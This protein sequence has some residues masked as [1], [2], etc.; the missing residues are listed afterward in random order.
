M[1]R[2][3]ALPSR[4]S[5]TLPMG[6]YTD[7]EILRA[8][9]YV[10]KVLDFSMSYANPMNFLRRISKADNYDIQTRHS[11]QVLYGDLVARLPAHGAP[12]L[13]RRCR[14]R[15]A[16]PRGP[17]ARRVDAD[18]GALLDLHEQELLA[19]P[20]SC[21]ILPASHHAS[22]LPQEVTRTRSSCA[23]AVRDR[24]G[25]QDVPEGVVG[26]DEEQDRTCSAST[27]TSARDRATGAVTRVVVACQHARDE[28]PRPGAL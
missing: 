23:P 7:V 6:G 5:T 28:Q 25:A 2:S 3:C 19:R 18:A 11:R 9:R 4:T 27:C 22:V 14:V 13:A 10:L 17:R 21:S 16:S 15:L 8:E 26:V 12:A 24:L 1:R 20:R